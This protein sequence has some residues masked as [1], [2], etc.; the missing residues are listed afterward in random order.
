MFKKKLRRL[1][2]MLIAG[3]MAVSMLGTVAFAEETNPAYQEQDVYILNHDGG[4]EGIAAYQYMSPYKGRGQMNLPDGAAFNLQGFVF[5]LYN[6]RTGAEIAAHCTDASVGLDSNSNY[7]RLNLED[8]SYGAAAAGKLRAVVRNGFPNVG[9]EELG[10]AA[11]VENLTLCE[12]VTASQFAV[13]KTVHG[14]DLTF[15]NYF[16]TLTTDSKWDSPDDALSKLIKH[17]AE[18]RAELDNSDYDSPSNPLITEHIVA[19]LNYLTSLQPVESTGVAVSAASFKEW[20]DIP[21][22]TKNEDGTYDVTV[23]AKVDVEMNDDDDMTLS[24]V[25]DNKIYFASTALSNVEKEYTLTI[26]NVPAEAARGVVTLAI[27]G[28]QTVED[29]F[30]FDAKGDRGVSQSLIGL[31]NSQLPVHAE[32]KVEPERIINFYKT[33]KIVTGQDAS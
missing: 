27:D 19:V 31:D 24:A 30:L 14:D 23:N 4:Y 3:A 7:R 5:N 18:C 9:V 15:L 2:A 6:P 1:S 17:Y 21:V 10:K 22:L 26:E 11:G 29:V 32:V 25:L 28:M 13:W 12:A 8:S 33:A 16:Y 20:S